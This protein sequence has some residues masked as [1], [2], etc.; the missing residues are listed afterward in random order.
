MEPTGSHQVTRRA[1]GY[2]VAGQL[3]RGT[4]R[5][6]MGGAGASWLFAGW[7]GGTPVGFVPLASLALGAEAVWSR[8]RDS[9]LGI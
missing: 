5:A 7:I 2:S 6:T 4:S 1:V 8:G 9:L 3:I